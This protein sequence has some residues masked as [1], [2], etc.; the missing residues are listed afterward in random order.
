[1]SLL[2]AAAVAAAI[3]GGIARP[4]VA[5]GGGWEI[6]GGYSLLE[7]RTINADFPA[8]WVAG[9]ARPVTGWMALVAEA[10]GHRKTIPTVAG[11]DLKLGV[12]TLMGGGRLSARAGRLAEFAQVLT[13]AVRGSGTIFD[14]TDT[15][16]DL[17]IQPGIGLDF[18]LTPRVAARAQ[19]DVRFVLRDTAA[20]DTGHQTRFAAG[21][22]F[23]FR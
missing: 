6:S 22:A 20:A 8:G 17:G 9:V 7:E 3:V 5:Q 13:G 14:V 10:G 16:T 1:M 23:R 4:A 11:A 15:T 12:L 19:V 2:R 18:M 21:L